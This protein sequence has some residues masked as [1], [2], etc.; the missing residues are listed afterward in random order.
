MLTV[1]KL[2]FVTLKDYISSW[3]EIWVKNKGTI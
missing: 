1:L 2:E 3:K